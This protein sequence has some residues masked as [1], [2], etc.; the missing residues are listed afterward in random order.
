MKNFIIPS[1]SESII[2]PFVKPITKTKLFYSR[3][4]ISEIMWISL[5]SVSRGWKKKEPPFDAGR[6]IGRRVI[7]PKSCL[8]NIVTMC[9]GNNKKNI[10]VSSNENKMEDGI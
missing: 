6:K 10:E 2:S 7:F 4:E 3:K 9:P 5:S 1:S 8:T